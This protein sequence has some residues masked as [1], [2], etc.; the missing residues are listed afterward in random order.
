MVDDR[1]TCD[2]NGGCFINLCDIGEGVT[3]PRRKNALPEMSTRSSRET[4]DR[5]KK[6]DGKKVNI[7]CEDAVRSPCMHNETCKKQR[8][9]QGVVLGVDPKVDEY[10]QRIKGKDAEEPSDTLSSN[11]ETIHNEANSGK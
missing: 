8:R 6:R 2:F 5:L 3:P 4:S 11:S 1:D 9:K 10:L 7:K